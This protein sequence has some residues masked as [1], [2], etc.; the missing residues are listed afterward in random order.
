MTTDLFTWT[1]RCSLIDMLEDFIGFDLGYD[2]M[3]AKQLQAKLLDLTYRIEKLVN[4]E[5]DLKM[6]GK[7]RQWHD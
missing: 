2:L 1:E 6:R 5:R 7:D 4:E 3:S